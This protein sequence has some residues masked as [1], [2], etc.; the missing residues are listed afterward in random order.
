MTNFGRF[1]GAGDDWNEMDILSVSEMLA[2][3]DLSL[4]KSTAVKITNYNKLENDMNRMIDRRHMTV[5]S[6][7]Q[8]KI[9]KVGEVGGDEGKF[10]CKCVIS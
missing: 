2:A 9:D 7:E 1:C 6:D 5:V 10:G 4:R 3:K 8:V